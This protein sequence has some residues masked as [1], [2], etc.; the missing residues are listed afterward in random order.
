[1]W[2][3]WNPNLKTDPVDSFLRGDN[4]PPDSVVI[5]V[6]YFDNPWFPEV[7]KVEMEYDL[8]RDPSKYAHVWLGKYQE[9]SEAR[10]FRNWKVEQF[11]A[12]EGAFFRLGADWGFSVDPSVLI[13]AR[14]EG[15]VLYIDYEAYMVGCEID[16]LPTLFD[17]V[18]E[19][20]KWFI[21]ADSAR[22]ETISY[23][24]NHGYPKINAAVKGAKS[25]EEGIEFLKSYDII[26]HPRCTHTIDE[27]TMYSF[28]CDPLDGRVTNILDDK[29]NH[30]IDALRYACESARKAVKPAPQTFVRTIQPQQ[31]GWMG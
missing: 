16:Q 21:T 28:K 7:L 3:S 5:E 30:V 24:R 31:H 2:F 22:P 15:K 6:N 25:I 13:R 9:N 27:L 1:L 8:K 26:V 14:I 20:R 12:P 10:V 11:T 18:P 19:S 29:H 4:P 23:M 17:R